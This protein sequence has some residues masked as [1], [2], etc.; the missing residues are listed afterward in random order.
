MHYK[1]LVKNY[2]TSFAAYLSLQLTNPS[3]KQQCYENKQHENFNYL[4]SYESRQ[5]SCSASIPQVH[6]RGT[7]QAI[8]HNLQ[9]S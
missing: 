8:Q 5:Q 6:A 1:K 4:S 9:N 2:K 3:P 7:K